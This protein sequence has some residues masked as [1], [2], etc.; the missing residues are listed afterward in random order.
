MARDPRKITVA[1]VARRMGVTQTWVCEGLISGRL[2]FGSAVKLPRGIRWGFYIAP[3][4][5]EAHMRELMK[6]GVKP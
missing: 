2:K 4:A 6:G 5:F 1:E 3:D